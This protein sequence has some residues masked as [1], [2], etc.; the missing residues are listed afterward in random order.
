MG[1]KEAIEIAGK[2]KK[3]LEKHFPHDKLYLYGSYA[4]GKSSED[5]D[6]DV[7]V[8]VNNIEGD[9]F[10]IMPV[11]WKLRRKVD[12]RIEPVLIDGSSDKSGFLNS[13]MK[14]GVEII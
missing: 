12:D 9:F 2:Y 3:L 11:L 10:E 7:A 6:I 4:T 8:I 14:T 5:S 1:K 13:I